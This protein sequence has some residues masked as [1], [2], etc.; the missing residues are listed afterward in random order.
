MNPRNLRR[1]KKIIVASI[2]SFTL[3]S[4]CT[5]LNAKAEIDLYSYWYGSVV[6][7][8][9]SVCGL[10]EEGVVSK[11]VVANFSKSFLLSI[12]D[13]SPK[14]ARKQALDYIGKSFT[15]CPFNE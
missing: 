14:L 4:T 9:A 11:K 3:L 13:E 5:S 1:M 2:G 10:I 12:K 6:G 8:G 7:A 15:E